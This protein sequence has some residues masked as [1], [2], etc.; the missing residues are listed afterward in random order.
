MYDTYS[1]YSISAAHLSGTTEVCISSPPVGMSVYTWKA[2]QADFW[3]CGHMKHLW[4][5]AYFKE[6]EYLHH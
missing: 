6:N 1:M 3:F 5:S 4:I 2:I